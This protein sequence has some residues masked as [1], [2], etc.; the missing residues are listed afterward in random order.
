MSAGHHGQ[1]A[2]AALQWTQ[3]VQQESGHGTAQP[4]DLLLAS[5][6][7]SRRACFERLL[8]Q[9]QRLQLISPTQCKPSTLSGTV[10]S[11]ALKVQ[12]K[13]P[14]A[15]GL[16]MHTKSWRILIQTIVLSLHTHQRSLIKHRSSDSHLVA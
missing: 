7:S 13:Y 12:L 8:A 2:R 10:E 15:R 9:D 11:T 14:E 6:V 1:S 5:V 4:S 16:D 3:H